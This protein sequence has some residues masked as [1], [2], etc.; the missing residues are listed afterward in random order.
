[1][2]EAIQDLPLRTSWQPRAS[3][4]LFQQASCLAAFPAQEKARLG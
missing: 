3:V 1:M 4:R 2:P